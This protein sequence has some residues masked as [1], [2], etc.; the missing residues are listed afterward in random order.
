MKRKKPNYQMASIDVLLSQWGKWSIR[1]ESGALGFAVS[2]ILAGIGTGDAFDSATPRGLID[3]DMEAVDG[4][5]RQLPDTLRVTVIQVYRHGAGWS[6][7]RN[8]AALKID[9]RTMRGYLD[10]ARRRLM[11]ELFN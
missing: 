8:A 6:Q 2:S 10:T 11:L 4:A 3:D 1:C 7:V 9:K 5:I